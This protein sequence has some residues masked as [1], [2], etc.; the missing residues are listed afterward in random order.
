MSLN[1]LSFD[2]DQIIFLGTG[3]GRFVV[4]NQLRASGGL[5]FSLSGKLFVIDPGPGALV[6]AFKH[7]IRPNKLSGIFLSH[8]HLDHC[9][10]INAIIESMTDGGHKKRGTIIAPK[11]AIE[12]DPVILKY[13][14]KNY[15]LINTKEYHKYEI[16]GITITTKMKH[17]HPVET[18]GA[19]F[20]NGKHSF[21]Y[22]AD[23]KYFADLPHEYCSDVVIANVVF[24]KERAGFQHLNVEDIYKFLEVCKPKKLIITHFGLSFLNKKPWE[25]AREISKKTGIEVIAA[26]DNMVVDL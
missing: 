3:G 4:F 2:K 7:K 5:W 19:V 12:I 6:K 18:Y 8:R 20:S 15:E 9:A 26:W 13:N 23:T 25:K 16:D 24:C 17:H 11:D 10:D 14:R 22:I 21:S 1:T